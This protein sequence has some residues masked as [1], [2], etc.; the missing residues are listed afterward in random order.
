MKKKII[1]FCYIAPVVLLIC[2]AVS[3]VTGYMRYS[4]TLNS[5]PFYVW[6]LVDAIYFVVPALGL[7]I[8][9]LILRKSRK[10]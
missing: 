6:V 3:I 4:S 1:K 7:F 5:A 2:F 10:E 8:V 9:G